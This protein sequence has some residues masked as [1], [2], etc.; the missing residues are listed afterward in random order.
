MKTVVAVLKLLKV[1]QLIIKTFP[2]TTT[3]TNLR[4]GNETGF[5]KSRRKEWWMGMSFFVR[6][7][8]QTEGRSLIPK[9]MGSPKVPWP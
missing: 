9:C 2:K 4:L 8:V 6:V 1:P 5:S 3:N 7:Y